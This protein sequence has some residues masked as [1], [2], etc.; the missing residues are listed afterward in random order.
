LRVDPSKDFRLIFTL[1]PETEIGPIIEPYVVQ[2]NSNETFSLTYQRVYYNTMQAF[3][4]GW[5]ET[6]KEIVKISSDYGLENIVKKFSKKDVRP[7]EFVS[8]FLDDKL[9][10]ETIRPF[11]EDRLAKCINLLKGHV[12]YLKGKSGN[13]AHREIEFEQ[14]QVSVIFHFIKEDTG[15]KYYPTFKC[16]N[17]NITFVNKQ[18]LIVTNKPCILLSESKLYYFEDTLEGKKLTPFFSKWNIEIPKSSEP[19]YFRRFIMPLIEKHKVKAKGFDIFTL[20]EDPVA[21]LKMEIGWNG[22][23][24]L[25][26]YFDYKKEK[27]PSEDPK[28]VYVKMEKS[29]E[30]YTY[31]KITRQ[32]ASENRKKEQ[33][34]NIGLIQSEGSAWKPQDLNGHATAFELVQWINRNRQKLEDNGFQVIQEGITGT[35]YL[36]EIH[37]NFDVKESTDWFDV[38]AT[39]SFGEFRIPFIR[40]KKYIL[41]EIS[42]FVLPDGKIAV[43]PREWF[44]KYKDLLALAGGDETRLMVKKH[45]YA[46]MDEIFTSNSSNAPIIHKDL[47]LSFN[48]II[49]RQYAN[50]PVTFKE[51]LRPY[52][53]SGFQW[54]NFLKKNK[55]GGCLADDMGLGKTIQALALLL[56]EQQNPEKQE[57]I[58]IPDT[59]TGQLSLFGAL[60]EKTN[61][62]A[63]KNHPSLIIMPTSLIH[64][65][66]YEVKKWA[67]ALNIV[68]YTGFD[69]EDKLK[70][71]GMA[72]II[73]TTYGTARN[74]IEVIKNYQFN[75]IILDESQVIKNPLAKV[76]KAVKTLQAH[77]RLG[78]S[79]TPV[80]NSLMDLWSQMSFLNP[81][82]LGSYQYFRDEFVIPIEKK[83]DEERKQKLKLLIQ[84]FILRRT[85]EQVAK[86]LP[87]LSEKV[88]F[89]E[90]TPDQ[91]ELYDSTR[92]FYRKKILENLE[93]FGEQRARFFVL[94][95]LMQLRQIANHPRMHDP[96]Y[97]GQSG[98]FDDITNTLESVLSEKHRVLIFSQFVRHLDLIATHL[99]KEDIP[100]GY[101]TGQTRKRAEEINAFKTDANKPVFLISL[102]AGGVG[103]NLTEADYVFICDPWWNPAV[104]Q[105]AINRAHRIGQDKSVFSYKFISKNTVEEKILTLQE[106]KM[107]LS[108]DLIQVHKSTPNILSKEDIDLLF[109]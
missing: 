30:N 93:D 54:M 10:K 61:G 91:Q 63:K 5:T 27:I 51:V 18:V 50:V 15:T 64:N 16:N 68:V 7:H 9:L 31:F 94:K 43:L 90:M 39:V 59:T 106:R 102:K 24:Q 11:V 41:N 57:P 82:L 75:Y 42:D 79:G 55:F 21:C 37:L 53:E 83:N 29:N 60:P 80:E 33:L 87:E 58:A 100:F 92:N 72:D 81:G 32:F 38:Y 4:E 48:D 22:Q 69:R 105:Q 20:H 49:N 96:A 73:L 65:W 89:S 104:E 35:Y 6:E 34:L 85:K 71:F 46:L 40:L 98:K 107:Q 74:D 13:P 44:T 99:K 19:Q 25:L 95:G 26:L 1:N 97:A 78:L 8:R 2:L 28:K 45:H 23:P 76:S 108:A 36:G 47:Y 88:Y 86:D 12:L 66:Q 103:L 109:S 67:P 52:Q 14:E 70:E 77:H 84:P 17:E 101:L 62:H 56:N 3:S